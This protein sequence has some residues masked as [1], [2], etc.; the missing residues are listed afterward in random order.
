M[1]GDTLRGNL[2]SSTT[3]TYKSAPPASVIHVREVPRMIP[4]DQDYRSQAWSR[5]EG[6]RPVREMAPWGRIRGN[7]LRENDEPGPT[8][9]RGLVLILRQLRNRRSL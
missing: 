8:L 1:E 4:T 3:R 2:Q 5:G 7:G 9:R 6:G